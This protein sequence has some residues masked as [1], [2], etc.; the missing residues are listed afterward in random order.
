MNMTYTRTDTGATDCARASVQEDLDLALSSPERVFSDA[1]LW[2]SNEVLEKHVR[3]TRIE[4]ELDLEDPRVVAKLIREQHARPLLDKGAAANSTSFG[5]DKLDGAHAKHIKERID[6]LALFRRKLVREVAPLLENE[7][8]QQERFGTTSSTSGRT[9]A[10][11]DDSSVFED[12]AMLAAFRKR[13]QLDDTVVEKGGAPSELAELG[14]QQSPIRCASSWLLCG[15]KGLLG[16]IGREVGAA[17]IATRKDRDAP[18]HK[19]KVWKRLRP[20]LEALIQWMRTP[21]K[22]RELLA[23][24]CFW[25]LFFNFDSVG[26]L[27]QLAGGK[28]AYTSVPLV[29]NSADTHK[30]SETKIGGASHTDGTTTS[31]EGNKNNV[32]GSAADRTVADSVLAPQRDDG[33][34]TVPTKTGQAPAG[35]KVYVYDYTTNTSPT[36]ANTSSAAV[37]SPLSDLVSSNFVIAQ[38]NGFWTADVYMHRFFQNSD[39]F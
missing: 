29:P 1:Q 14:Q 34:T 4:T 17:H 31:T 15:L 21:G 16:R 24:D 23:N 11:Q 19:L 6:F 35:I 36:T 25:N 26:H 20:W 30:T 12:P 32:K 10:P 22:G 33:P 9:G 7:R 13:L 27:I 28:E 3:E 5:E 38:E 18:A 8:Q 39:I 37:S 2:A